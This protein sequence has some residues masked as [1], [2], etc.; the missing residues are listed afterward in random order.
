MLCAAGRWQRRGW[1]I[2]HWC[3]SLDV[4][5]RTSYGIS[6]DPTS[7]DAQRLYVDNLPAHPNGQ[8]RLE[9]RPR[10]RAGD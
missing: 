8:G 10:M 5:C 2:M 3:Q 1:T 7:G 6:A 4:W 9:L